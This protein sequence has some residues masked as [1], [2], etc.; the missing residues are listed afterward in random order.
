SRL[1]D[2][3]AG[4]TERV[5]VEEI[6]EGKLCSGHGR[7]II[8]W[9]RGINRNGWRYSAFRARL[10]GTLPVKACQVVS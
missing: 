8:S 7:G 2:G 4:R 3:L 9:D 10:T 6:V 1:C 5:D